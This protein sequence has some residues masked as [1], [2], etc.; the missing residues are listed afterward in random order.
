MSD[1]PGHAAT[2]GPVGPLT[3]DTSARTLPPALTPVTCATPAA[4]VGDPA[5]A[6]G[7]LVTSEEAAIGA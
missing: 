1:L 4:I 3:P 2:H 5:V 6:I 7:A